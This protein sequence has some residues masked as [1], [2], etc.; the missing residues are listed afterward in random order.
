M[1][2]TLTLVDS[3]MGTAQIVNNTDI[4]TDS[5]MK[6]FQGQHPE[7]AALVTWTKTASGGSG[8]GR[9]GGLFERDRYVTPHSIFDQFRVA[10]DA[11]EN[12]DVVS[13][14]IE[15]TES[16]AFS[17]MGFLAEDEDEEDIWNQIASDID[18]DSP[19]ARDVAGALHGQPVLLPDVVGP[20]VLQ[21]P[22]Q[23]RRGQQE[24]Q[25]VR[26]H[27]RP[28]GHVDPGPAQGRARRQRPVRRRAAVLHRGPHRARHARRRLQR[29]SRG[30]PVARQI[31]IQKYAPTT[32]SGSGSPTWTSRT[33]SCTC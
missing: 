16:L 14:I 17:K 18:L 3:Q 6:A 21:G 32:S 12:D 13:G 31:I 8:R 19:A 2:G 26:Q 15:S 24:A 28:A 1:E 33:T 30:R 7:V 29:R 5:I 10:H 27:L 20:E 23:D 25:D 4:E 22:G 11:A 9:L